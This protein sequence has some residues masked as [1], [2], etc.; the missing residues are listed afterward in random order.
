MKMNISLLRTIAGVMV[1]GFSLGSHAQSTS[2]NSAKPGPKRRPAAKTHKVWTEDDIASVRKPADKFIDAQDAQTIQAASKES[3]PAAPGKQTS[4]VKPSQPW[5]AVAK[6]V[7][8]ADEKIAWEERDIQG[9]KE[10]IERLQQQLAVVPPDQRGHLQELIK[11]H[12][13]DL[14]GTEKERQGLLEQKKVL[15][16]KAADASNNP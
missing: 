6:S 9:Q 12:Q 15:Q 2:H 3:A 14:A 8:E 1:L 10:T 4:A 5:L 11:Q 13:Q 16:K 7:Q